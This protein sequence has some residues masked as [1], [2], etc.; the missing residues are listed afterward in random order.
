MFSVQ[1]VV[2]I[3]NIDKGTELTLCY[4]GEKDRFSN[5]DKRRKVLRNY[6]FDCNCEVCKTEEELDEDPCY[7]T[8]Y[9]KLMN[10]LDSHKVLGSTYLEKETL[11]ETNMSKIIW[12]IQNLQDAIHN[13]DPFSQEYKLIL[14]KYS[15]LE[16]LMKCQKTS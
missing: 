3:R 9:L 5:V 13:V 11:L 15:H 2:A 8:N 7:L 10:K 16:Q 6:G 12:R 4:L 1:S 14:D